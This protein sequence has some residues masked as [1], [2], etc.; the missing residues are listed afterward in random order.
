MPYSKPMDFPNL[1]V[2]PTDPETANYQNYL[3]WQA[4]HEARRRLSATHFSLFQ[5]RTRERSW[6]QAL[7]KEEAEQQAEALKDM[8]ER[9]LSTACKCDD[10]S[11]EK[12][13]RSN[14]VSSMA[15]SSP[16]VSARSSLSSLSSPIT[17]TACAGSRNDPSGKNSLIISPPPRSRHHRRRCQSVPS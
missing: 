1:K 7:Y 10:C 11:R 2:P 14:S 6:S 5:S 9:R 17:K 16:T 15:P 3:A 13:E 4:Q 12:K 8:I